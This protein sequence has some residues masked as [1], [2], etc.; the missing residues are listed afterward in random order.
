MKTKIMGAVA[1]VLVLGFAGMANATIVQLDLFDLGCPTEFNWDNSYWRTDF[2]LG[3]TFTEI[4][5]VY[6]DWS[7][8][9]TAGLAVEP[10]RPGQQPFPLEVGI[11]ASLGGFPYPRFA[12][13]WGG[14]QFIQPPSHLTVYLNLSY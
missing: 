12:Q 1:V 3:V 2:D 14:R 8:E 13:V 4:S 5:N 9:I 10:T 11:G 7:G 6:I